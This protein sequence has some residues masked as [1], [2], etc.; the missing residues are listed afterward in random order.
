MRCACRD[1]VFGIDMAEGDVKEEFVLC[2]SL[3]NAV[4]H[5]CLS[6]V[7]FKPSVIAVSAVMFE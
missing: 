1:D 5:F 7:F 2:A 3:V 4:A 6:F